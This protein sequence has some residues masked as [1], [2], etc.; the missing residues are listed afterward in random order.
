[1]KKAKI[2]S[3]IHIETKDKLGMLAE[4]TSAISAAGANIEALCAYGME[5]KARFMLVADD[6]EKA[7]TGL[8]QKG[9]SLKEEDVVMVSLAN[10]VGAAAKM[11]EKLKAAKINLSY[12]YGSTSKASEAPMVLKSSNDAKAVEILG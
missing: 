5:G 1:M 4:V 10:K 3:Q 9:Y 2:V 7:L 6:N 8:R 12:I 11:S